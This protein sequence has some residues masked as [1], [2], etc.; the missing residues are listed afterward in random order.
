MKKLDDFFFAISRVIIFLPIIIIFFGLITKSGQVTRNINIM[1]TPT[2][3]VVPNKQSINLKGP[4]HCVYKNKEADFE[5]FIKDYK[6]YATVVTLK[7]KKDE[8]Y[9]DGDCIYINKV[10]KT[11]NVKPYISVIETMLGSGNINLQSLP[12]KELKSINIQELL[13]GCKYE[14]FDEILNTKF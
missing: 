7:N 9:F 11:C 1:M 10:K 6:A 12:N 14:E 2:P 3:T 13:K 4:F 5:A 8:F